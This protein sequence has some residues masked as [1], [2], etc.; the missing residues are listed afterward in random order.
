MIIDSHVHYGNSLWGN[1]SP[2]DLINI[3][4]ENIEFAICSNLEGIDSPNF[5]FEL[6][7]NEQMLE[8][9]KKFPKLKPL[10]VCQPNLTE[11]IEIAK[12]FLKNH[13]EFIGLKIHPECMKLPADSEKYNKYL[14]LAREFKKPCLYHSGH[15]KSRFSSPKLI[16]KKAQEFP[17][18][19]IILGHLSTGPKE[20]H[21]EAINIL[22][23]S[24]ENEKATLYVDTSWIDFAYEKLNESYEDTIMLIEA[25]K[26]TTKGDFTNRILWASDSPVGKFN[27]DKKSYAYNIQVFKSRIKEHFQ[28]ETL[29][30]NLLS[31]NAKNLYNI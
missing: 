18:V 30:K 23:D 17:D 16:Y 27:Q 3:I 1:F 24:I 25:L 12:E 10:Y 28:D 2:E 7:C 9:A 19:P 29:L 21:I 11:N 5:K 6:E 4:G 15:I 14:E 13:S 31:K 26:N 8:T 22:L 20:S